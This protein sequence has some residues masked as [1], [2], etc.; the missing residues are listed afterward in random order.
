MKNE[1]G[2]M[3]SQKKLKLALLASL[4]IIVM[5]GCERERR[6]GGKNS[7]LG[8]DNSGSVSRVNDIS[9][10]N[11]SGDD[12]FSSDFSL[13]NGKE[14]FSSKSYI[15]DLLD[16][17][18]KKLEDYK[19]KNQKIENKKNFIEIFNAYSN[20]KNEISSL[21]DESIKPVLT[22][23]L[24]TNFDL[25]YKH[26]GQLNLFDADEYRLFVELIENQYGFSD[27]SIFMDFINHRH[28][29]SIPIGFD[30]DLGKSYEKLLHFY[31][32][33]ANQA[34][35]KIARAIANRMDPDGSLIR[36][37]QDRQRLYQNIV[38]TSKN[39]YE[40]L[41]DLGENSLPEK[42]ALLEE[43]QRYLINVT[44]NMS[45]YILDAK[46]DNNDLTLSNVSERLSYEKLVNIVIKIDYFL[47]RKRNIVFNQGRLFSSRMK[48]VW[49]SN[50][51]QYELVPYTVGQNINNIFGNGHCNGFVMLTNYFDEAARIG[52]G[53]IVATDFLRY[54]ETATKYGKNINH[55]KNFNTPLIDRWSIAFEG[56]FSGITFAQNMQHSTIPLEI[57][58]SN[59]AV[60]VLKRNLTDHNQLF[61]LS[62]EDR[63]LRNKFLE[64]SRDQNNYGR[65]F[66]ITV[67]SVNRNAIN[68]P[69]IALNV[70]MGHIVS[71]KINGE[72]SFSYLDPN[73][74]YKSEFNV[75]QL[76]DVHLKNT[77]ASLSDNNVR[78]YVSGVY[79]SEIKN[80][81]YANDML[82]ATKIIY[83]KIPRV[84]SITRAL[85]SIDNGNL[86]K[87]NPNALPEEDFRYLL[88]YELPEPVMPE[89]NGMATFKDGNF[90]SSVMEGLELKISFIGL[91]NIHLNNMIRERRRLGLEVPQWVTDRY[92]AN[93]VL[94]RNFTDRYNNSFLSIK[95]NLNRLKGELDVLGNRY[96][97]LDPI[98]EQL[99]RANA[100]QQ[101]RQKLAEL[102]AEIRTAHNAGQVQD[103]RITNQ[104]EVYK[105]E[106]IVFENN[107]RQLPRERAAV[108][109]PVP[110]DRIVRPNSM[111]AVA[112]KIEE[113]EHLSSIPK[114]KLQ[115]IKAET[116]K[117]ILIKSEMLKKD[118][119][120]FTREEIA[121]FEK[122]NQN[123]KNRKWLMRED[124]SGV[125][126]ELKD[127]NS[128]E[129]I[130]L[131]TEDNR[132]KDYK[133]LT[134][135]L[136]TELK[137]GGLE[138]EKN[139]SAGT[140][141][142]NTILNA[143]NIYKMLTREGG[144]NSHAAGA[145][146]ITGYGV[147]ASNILNDFVTLSNKAIDLAN[148]S[149]LLPKKLPNIP[150]EAAGKVIG[151]VGGAIS[152]YM[153]VS[154]YIDSLTSTLEAL[155]DKNLSEPEKYAIKVRFTEASIS[156]ISNLAAFVDPTGGVVSSVVSMD[157]NDA[158]EAAIKGKNVYYQFK[159]IS[160]IFAK[161]YEGQKDSFK[162]NDNKQIVIP[163]NDAIIS[164]IDLGTGKVE[165]GQIKT[166]L[167][168]TKHERENLNK[169]FIPEAEVQIDA[170]VLSK[171][172]WVVPTSPDIEFIPKIVKREVL[173]DGETD[174]YESK[175]FEKL[176]EKFQG[177]FQKNGEKESVTTKWTDWM[178]F[179]YG[180]AKK[181]E[182]KDQYVLTGKFVNIDSTRTIVFAETP[183]QI[184]FPDL[185]NSANEDKL[186]FELIGR[187]STN[188]ITLGNSF[189][190][191][192]VIKS[193][194][195]D[196]WIIDASKFVSEMP[197][198]EEYKNFKDSS[199]MYFNSLLKEFT[200]ENHG[201][202]ASG[203]RIMDNLNNA[204]NAV[205]RLGGY[206]HALKGI[207]HISVDLNPS[208]VHLGELKN[209]I[210]K[211][212]TKI[213]LKEI[214]KD[215]MNEYFSEIK[216]YSADLNNVINALNKILKSKDTDENKSAIKNMQ[217]KMNLFVR[218]AESQTRTEDFIKRIKGLRFDEEK[219]EIVIPNI[220]ALK[221]EEK[222]KRIQVEGNFKNL[223]FSINLDPYGY[224][225]GAKPTLQYVYDNNKK[226]FFVNDFSF[227]QN[228][229]DYYDEFDKFDKLAAKDLFNKFDSLGV[230]DVNLLGYSNDGRLTKVIN[231]KLDNKYFEI[232]THDL[233][234]AKYHE[235]SISG[236]GIFQNNSEKFFG[237]PFMPF[238]E[239][240]KN[241]EIF[242]S[243]K[244]IKLI[245]TL[246]E[247]VYLVTNHTAEPEYTFTIK[248]DGDGLKIL[249]YEN[250]KETK[251]SIGFINKMIEREGGDIKKLSEFR[252]DLAKE[253]FN[254]FFAN[255]LPNSWLKDQDI[256]SDT[257]YITR[258]QGSNVNKVNITKSNIIVTYNTDA[259]QLIES[260]KD[261]LVYA[262]LIAGLYRTYINLNESFAN[263]LKMIRPD[264]IVIVPDITEKTLKFPNGSF[265]GGKNGDKPPLVFAQQLETLNF[266]ENAELYFMK[267][268]DK[269]AIGG[270]INRS[271]NEYQ[272]RLVKLFDYHE[273]LKVN[274][275]Y[276]IFM[277]NERRL[278]ALFEK[279]VLDQ[280]PLLFE[281]VNT[282]I[283][284]YRIEAEFKK[285][286]E[287]YKIH[288]SGGYNEKNEAKKRMDK[289]LEQDYPEILEQL[290]LKETDI[291]KFLDIELK[292]YIEDKYFQKILNGIRANCNRNGGL[293]SRL[294][295][296]AKEIREKIR[297]HFERNKG[298]TLLPHDYERFATDVRRI[299]SIAKN[300]KCGKLV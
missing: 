81:K 153:G 12:D 299:I 232:R 283:N 188:K 103:A 20:L 256:F 172:I 297:E 227:K 54:I 99:Q 94:K 171:N 92:N 112:S 108:P 174:L 128:K 80:I 183:K 190:K 109:I 246:E 45:N 210:D 160:D 3:R 193:T 107:F 287:D 169:A 136:K 106:N 34:G 116:S 35:D 70:S 157:I 150:F 42:R 185:E 30:P 167:S 224:F 74:Y 89:H 245:K 249:S 254:A 176:K 129:T 122:H 275:N 142:G 13:Y 10:I 213:E 177:I 270:T 63:S 235:L 93:R 228:S 131:N 291:N 293:S 102:N 215:N 67:A 114:V 140:A 209:S 274:N 189:A 38:Q 5:V 236:D 240:T 16:V 264:Q 124:S 244:P 37:L 86:L 292:R 24:N 31:H 25:L 161:I 288:K 64:M 143:A 257:E 208:P 23:F 191:G 170:N 162:L 205:H 273:S 91:K 113:V 115:E 47:G 9:D 268:S 260:K 212:N 211:I 29:S 95:N 36:R 1:M 197:S 219:K 88:N 206:A 186:K 85:E 75:D 127:T 149:K 151:K 221:E 234:S 266:T 32:E 78:S 166:I 40:R 14:A 298:N 198:L 48:W 11:Y 123:L 173:K 27:D 2:V 255:S 7:S 156:L 4:P 120:A 148:V 39:Y 60:T 8:S 117:Q 84:K 229:Q 97:A 72:N 251:F 164:Q 135:Y 144:E 248:V 98:R 178:I 187:G 195:K 110:G 155:K 196:S 276:G 101:W 277:E 239:Q 225:Y 280:Y 282:Y 285:Y 65:N 201:K 267:S 269:I 192:I 26:R 241:L 184:V 119:D 182:T 132:Y 83:S 290:E 220:M 141:L 41:N 279:T 233:I 253:Y 289:F 28:F 125:S 50:T 181:L 73:Y 207:L 55:I 76:I 57:T 284:E 105:R 152:L 66:A 53:N 179:W 261:N 237:R 121:K 68:N 217:D 100:L 281:K 247:N 159:Y 194:D 204:V 87:T 165:Y 200:E 137:K 278:K 130:R 163:N 242:R 223:E 286:L 6:S 18:L 69:N 238:K 133:R 111:P 77:R 46:I 202:S 15:A 258:R 49:N 82:K 56:L 296:F 226:Q 300:E 21:D 96:F 33:L 118:F 71:F 175:G 216:N 90:N 158:L 222:E 218:Y 168:E 51:N 126:W 214:N 294:L 62:F 154:D 139:R 17:L 22:V 263:I 44:E 265:Y 138:F 231:N 146:E 243:D 134:E 104:F 180:L 61:N 262:Y 52:N 203:I 59:G 230:K 272:K 259:G 43:Y 252:A 250:I 295:S 199:Y 271:N 79:T 58:D 19:K 147:L 145:L